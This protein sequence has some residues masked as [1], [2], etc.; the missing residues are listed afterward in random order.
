MK[1][2]GMDESSHQVGLEKRIKEKLEKCKGLK[3]HQLSFKPR[4]SLRSADPEAWDTENSFHV[5]F[6]HDGTS[7]DP[8]VWKL[9]PEGWDHEHCYACMVRID[10]GTECWETKDQSRQLCLAC[11][12]ALLSTKPDS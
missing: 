5:S 8:A 1:E 12:E 7:F 10:F 4:A 2:V 9:M 3:F 11:H 6:P